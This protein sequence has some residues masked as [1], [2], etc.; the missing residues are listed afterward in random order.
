MSKIILII[1]IIFVLSNCSISQSISVELKNVDGFVEIVSEYN[2]SGISNDT[3]YTIRD[4][5]ITLRD[6]TLPDKRGN[7]TYNIFYVYII[8]A[9]IDLNLKVFRRDI[10]DN[11][12]IIDFDSIQN[13]INKETDL[14][15]KEEQEQKSDLLYRSEIVLT[16]LEERVKHYDRMIRGKSSNK[17]A[18]IL[19]DE[20]FSR[21]YDTK[22]STIYTIYGATW[23]FD[24]GDYYTI[25]I[26]TWHSYGYSKS[27]YDIKYY[28]YLKG[29]GYILYDSEETEAARKLFN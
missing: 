24:N 4:T 7:H 22:N 27:Y 11:R 13:A 9:S 16:E 10:K 23:T 26:Y 19:Y 21:N 2:V 15:I 14:I 12:I 28:V 1:G 5:I 6:K 18:D 29:Y 20:G 8:C 17:V 25:R 3:S